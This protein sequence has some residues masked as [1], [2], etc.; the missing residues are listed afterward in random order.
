MTSQS[1]SD[2]LVVS[3]EAREAALA[4]RG[5]DVHPVEFY[6]N[7]T[8]VQAFARFEAQTLE[9]AAGVA[10]TIA[11]EWGE[12]WQ[13]E[14]RNKTTYDGGR[15]AGWSDGASDVAKAIRRSLKGGTG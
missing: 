1:Q 3:Q 13:K 4:I 11:D 12:R 6:D 15:V 7:T 10:E 5:E 8:I 14:G 2:A 9:R